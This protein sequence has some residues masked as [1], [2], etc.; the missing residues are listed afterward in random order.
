MSL[1]ILLVGLWRQWKEHLFPCIELREKWIISNIYVYDIDIKWIKEISSDLWLIQLESLN[2][3]VNLEIK[4]AIITVPNVHHFEISKIVIENN[5][6][7][8]IEKPLYLSINEYKKIEN[9]AIKRKL[10]LLSCQQRVYSWFYE[11]IEEKIKNLWNIKFINY[12]FT[13]N[14][15]NESWYYNKKQWWWALM[16]LSWHC[17]YFF[18]Y[19]FWNSKTI[20]WK[21]LN[22]KNRFFSYDSDD[23][24]VLVLEYDN[25]MT[26]HIYT[27]CVSS[28]K[29]EIIEIIWEN[30]IFYIDREKNILNLHWNEVINDNVFKSWYSEQILN[31]INL[32][33][34]KK[35]IIDTVWV[36]T[37]YDILNINTK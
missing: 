30:G 2:N 19:F 22:W 20:Y 37:L 1:N 12:T 34:N 6:N 26:G 31:F 8:L 24:N 18:N 11:L 15:K 23:T 35:N 21:I 28:L 5:I 33:N 16:W 7:I 36:K 27:S 3:L 29:R 10:L 32:L 4:L 17:L 13:L 25:W 14:D 9:E